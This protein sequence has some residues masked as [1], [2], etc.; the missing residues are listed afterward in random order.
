MS[1]EETNDMHSYIKQILS[2][3]QAIVWS[4]GAIEFHNVEYKGMQA[5]RFPVNGFLH[6]GYVVV[7]YNGGSDAF[8]VYC[9]NEADEVVKSND[10]VYLNELVSTIDSMVE[11]EGS[12]QEYD[13]KRR[14]WLQ[15]QSE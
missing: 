3:S 14:E 8:E 11:K 13:K 12:N 4:W 15:S 6:K 10:D 2:H 7:A 5:L 1:T 9:L